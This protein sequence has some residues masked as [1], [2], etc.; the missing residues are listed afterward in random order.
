MDGQ[1]KNCLWG[2]LVFTKLIENG[3]RVVYRWASL[4][5]VW[6]LN[7]GTIPPDIKALHNKADQ[8]WLKL[9][10]GLRRQDIWLEKIGEGTFLSHFQL[11]FLH[12]N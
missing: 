9:Y 6:H 7:S 1:W 10:E 3:Y 8:L 2:I 12:C 5:P 4:A 11:F